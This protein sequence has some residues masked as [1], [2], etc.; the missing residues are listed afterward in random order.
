MK[1]ENESD[2]SIMEVCVSSAD[3]ET[4]FALAVSSEESS[5]LETEKFPVFST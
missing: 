1:R 2:G 5:D 4:A 3:E